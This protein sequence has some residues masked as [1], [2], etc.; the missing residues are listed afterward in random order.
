M[1]RESAAGTLPGFVETVRTMGT[2]VTLDVRAARTQ[3]PVAA[4]AD[5][6]ADLHRVDRLL[7]TWRAGSWASRLL[8][9]EVV[10]GDCP[11][12]VREVVGLAE[13]LAEVTDG[14]F[15]P[16]W[17]GDAAS[18]PDP[19]GLVKGWAAQRASDRLLAHGL[20]DHL[21]NA[22]G[23][24]VVSGSPDPGQGA[25]SAWRI[26]IADPLR[27]GALVGVLD[28][29]GGAGRWGVAPSGPAERGPQVVD[30]H[31]GAAPLSV[32]SATAVARVGTP[33]EEAGAWTDA[34]ATALVAAGG[35]APDLLGRLAARGVDAFLVG[36]DGQVT[37]PA[38]LLTG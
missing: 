24:L 7:S 21:V 15:S 30:P 27:P 8:R 37:D 10:V 25:A 1:S 38:G 29:A 6:A 36:A 32:A 17:R 34:C 28:L 2:V 11:A 5:A 31:T 18:G 20:P 26:G 14:W 9:R 3:P 12:P 16:Y 33:H 19:T 23:D 4:F 13:R 35:R 22:A